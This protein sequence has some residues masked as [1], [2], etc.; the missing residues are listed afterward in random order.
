LWF[1][2]QFYPLP[3]ISLLGQNEYR[4]NL[5]CC[6][7]NL[8]QVR[9]PLIT[10][11]GTKSAERFGKSS[12]LSYL[13]S[14]K[15]PAYFSTKN[16][17]THLG[18]VDLYVNLPSDQ[19][20]YIVAD[21]QSYREGDQEFLSMIAGVLLAS[22]VVLVHIT[23]DDIRE[24]DGKVKLNFRTSKKSK[25]VYLWR[26]YD[27]DEDSD[28]FEK[29]E[30]SLQNNELGIV[31]IPKLDGQQG[32]SVQNDKAD[33]MKKIFD[34]INTLNLKDFTPILDLFKI[35]KLGD[36]TSVLEANG[37]PK[38]TEF[39]R[40][41]GETENLLNQEIKKVAGQSFTKSLLPCSFQDHIIIEERKKKKALSKQ[42]LEE[43]SEEEL[44]KHEEKY[45]Q[46]ENR[47]TEAEA[48]KKKIQASNM[49]QKVMN[50]IASN[51]LH[52]ILLLSETIN[53]WKKPHFEELQN[54]YIELSSKKDGVNVSE[55]QKKALVVQ[56][57]D[58]DLSLSTF[59]DEVLS[60]YE[61]NE[62]AK[63]TPEYQGIKKYLLSCMLQG[64]PLNLVNGKTLKFGNELFREIFEKDI[65]SDEKI[66]II[67]IIGAQSSAKSTLL[68]VLFGC[69][70]STSAGRCTKGIYISL[71][72]H[73]S[74]F[75][76]MVIDTEGL[77]SVMAR[78]H[79]FDNLITTMTFSCSHVV[80]INN[81]GEINAK[82]RDLLEICVYAMKH[83]KLAAIKPKII[84]ALRDIAENSAQ[85]QQ[86]M[87]L[88][89]KDNLEQA[90]SNLSININQIIDF[91]QED[92]FLLPSA[93]QLIQGDNKTSIQKNNNLFSERVLEM[94]QYIFKY[95]T[96]IYDQGHHNPNLLYIETK[97]LWNDITEL[98]SDIMR[99]KNFLEIELKD[100]ALGMVNVIYEDFNE[101][102][103]ENGQKLV[104][105]H[106]EA[107][108]KNDLNGTAKFMQLLTEEFKRV[109]TAAMNELDNKIF[110][111][112]KYNVL[113]NYFNE[114]REI[115]DY[116]LRWQ[117][118][119]FLDDWNATIIT[120]ETNKEIKKFQGEIIQKVNEKLQTISLENS[121]EEINN[122][123]AELTKRLQKQFNEK[124]QRLHNNITQN[125]PGEIYAYF[126]RAQQKANRDKAGSRVLLP[127]LPQIIDRIRGHSDHEFDPHS[128]YKYNLG[129]TKRREQDTVTIMDEFESFVR[130]LGQILDGKPSDVNAVNVIN[131]YLSRLK[132]M[133]GEGVSVNRATFMNQ[134]LL[135]AMCF[136]YKKAH[137]IEVKKIEQKKIDFDEVLEEQKERV[138]FL[139]DDSSDSYAKGLKYAEQWFRDVKTNFCNEKVLSIQAAII[140]KIREKF[141]TPTAANHVAYKHAF[142]KTN[143][144]KD[145]D[146]RFEY[147]LKYVRDINLY[148]Q[149]IYE[150]E[151]NQLKDQEINRHIELEASIFISLIRKTIQ[152]VK[153]WRDSQ[154]GKGGQIQL[155]SLITFI[156]KNENLKRYFPDLYAI[157][158]GDIDTF[159]RG[160]TEELAKLIVKEENVKTVLVEAITKKI[161]E[162]LQEQY[163]SITGCQA[164]CPICGNKCTKADPAH[165]D[166]QTNCHLLAGFG[167]V[168]TKNTDE[169]LLRHCFDPKNYQNPWIRGEK[170]YD[171]YD[172]MIDKE[173]GDWR[174]EFPKKE[175]Q[176]NLK[177]EVPEELKKAWVGVMPVLVKFYGKKENTPK[178]WLSLVQE[179]ERLPAD[180]M[181]E[182]YMNKKPVQGEPK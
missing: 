70:F 131:N 123:F 122:Y 108:K 173:F 102:L 149:E 161:Q 14:I 98:S 68:N 165:V 174:Q 104:N 137:E 96:S 163:K 56:M 69:G 62:D 136:E 89:M 61:T 125:L 24:E 37:I 148:I 99:A 27:D 156:D 160:S 159:T 57:D 49:V 63:N 124:M 152:A 153:E 138:T 11:I 158:L 77:L 95:L 40:E 181:L 135:E 81:K 83:L 113:N 92:M 54:K 76:I 103:L 66:F 132:K 118:L 18:A 44:G 114:F 53:K 13:F 162:Y 116:N 101:K 22:Q 130:N 28:L 1:S 20:N 55:D 42:L 2:Y 33:A 85:I 47:I 73:P 58:K 112:K 64:G 139:L 60:Y 134:C 177:G 129:K 84:F 143:G 179:N 151:V 172:E 133:E 93:F 182:N 79:E 29:V 111:N 16:G 41:A 120:W 170:R 169:L 78:D 32:Y 91:S 142:H 80:I 166:H 115:V 175:K 150:K 141:P 7:E 51:E 157:T 94:R 15:D 121:I 10:S 45:G 90:A 105:T 128:F 43:T 167:G 178:D 5:N 38:D 74:G 23:K 17:F 146:K 127:P 107:L 147:S 100:D 31:G 48:S 117:K 65:K 67:S 35:F 9:K 52:R 46:I 36:G 140:E 71:L 50:V 168:Y 97:Q 19:Q 154:S 145:Y 87:L 21:V 59:L 26:D 82:L 39:D 106:K 8:F 110:K 171:T 144:D 25:I 30:S 34:K 88:K 109:R 75:K 119:R 4:L 72:R 3:L 164:K 6:T 126:D 155:G 180:T 86:E 12:F 176:N